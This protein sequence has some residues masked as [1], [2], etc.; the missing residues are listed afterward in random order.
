MDVARRGHAFMTRAMVHFWCERYDRGQ[1]YTTVSYVDVPFSLVCS[2]L[3]RERH[4]NT[5]G[6]HGRAGFIALLLIQARTLETKNSEENYA[7]CRGGRRG[8]VRGLQ[9]RR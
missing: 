8:G 5:R 6:R 1:K 3:F 4:V 9:W 2:A 7:F